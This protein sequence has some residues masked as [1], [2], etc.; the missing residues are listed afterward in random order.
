LEGHTRADIEFAVHQCAQ[1]T[2]K[3]I[4]EHE[5]ALKCI[6]WYLRGTLEKGIILTLT[7]KIQVGFYPDADFA[8]LYRTRTSKIFTVLEVELVLLFWSMASQSS[9]NPNSKLK[10]L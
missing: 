3:P 8:D 7:N 4:A 1:Y 10:L 5:A 9:G 6:R 2:F